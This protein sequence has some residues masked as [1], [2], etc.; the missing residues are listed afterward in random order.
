MSSRKAS[1]R[2]QNNNKRAEPYNTR[3][4]KNDKPSSNTR[5]K[6]ITEAYD[7][8]DKVRPSPPPGPA[9]AMDTDDNDFED[10]QPETSSNNKRN[11]IGGSSS[12]DP[13]DP[14]GATEDTNQKKITENVGEDNREFENVNKPRGAKALGLLEKIP[15]KSNEQKRKSV[16]R[17]YAEYPGYSGTACQTV[18]NIRY[19]VLYFNTQD[20]LVQAIDTP[21]TVSETETVKFT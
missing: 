10:G 15:G 11:D 6:V 20:E 8:H 7:Q 5:Q 13:R 19:I 12:K 18:K 2:N 9:E 3:A 17:F 4:Y 21:L 16:A 1:G 14:K